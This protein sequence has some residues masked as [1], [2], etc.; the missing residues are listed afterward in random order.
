MARTEAIK[1]V[2]NKE[3]A[4]TDRTDHPL[5]FHTRG[6]LVQTTPMIRSSGAAVIKRKLSEKQ[7]GPPAI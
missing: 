1:T 3:R 6:P 5:T 2:Y 4:A 7:S